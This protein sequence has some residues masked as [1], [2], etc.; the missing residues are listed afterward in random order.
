MSLEDSIYDFLAFAFSSVDPLPV[1]YR[2]YDK[3]P[4]PDPPCISFYTLSEDA[5]GLGASHA[6]P[7]DD[8]SDSIASQQRE[9]LQGTLSLA[10]YGS[11]AQ[12]WARF[13]RSCIKNTQYR[14]KLY[15]LGLDLKD[16]LGGIVFQGM[17]PG[18]SARGGGKIYENRANLDLQYSFI[19]TFNAV[20]N[21]PEFVEGATVTGKLGSRVQLNPQE[22]AD[23]SDTAEFEITI[24]LPE[25]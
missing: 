5:K 25:D 10:F 19:D 18:D 3:A 21:A 11:T 6:Y 14:E 22:P 17:F 15:E 2:E 9:L 1:I 16:S 23:S 13:V 24:T 7:Y 12:A 4:R 20:T 8:G